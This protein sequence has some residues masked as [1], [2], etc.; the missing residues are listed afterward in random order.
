MIRL[1]NS[2]WIWVAL[3]QIHNDRV[4]HGTVAEFR[5]RYFA[6]II[7]VKLLKKLLRHFLRRVDGLREGGYRHLENCLQHFNMRTVELS[8]L[9]PDTLYKC[10]FT[11]FWNSKTGLKTANCWPVK[12]CECFPL[13]LDDVIDQVINS[14]FICDLETVKQ[15]LPNHV[16]NNSIL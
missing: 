6:V 9:L 8:L 15:L 7:D 12:S 13:V 3:K 1:Q 11:V 14:Y 2:S 16:R 5:P 10:I 4:A